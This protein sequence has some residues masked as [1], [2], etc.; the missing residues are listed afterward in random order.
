MNYYNPKI[1][2]V[3]LSLREFNVAR[4][5]L[6]DPESKITAEFSMLELFGEFGEFANNVKKCERE[7]LGLVG[8]RVTTEEL[9]DE[10]A[11]VY[12]CLDLLAMRMGI[13]PFHP[14]IQNDEIV[15]A[16]STVPTLIATLGMLFA[17]M[18]SCVTLQAARDEFDVNAGM[19]LVET[20][21]G[22]SQ[23]IIW[24][25]DLLGI[26]VNQ[27]V[28]EKFNQTSAKHGFDVLIP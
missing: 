24:I 16:Q 26:D 7:C 6:W 5:Q 4:Q 19:S 1:I 17:I 3:L 20:F 22:A 10:L 23:I 8:S 2:P 12:I 11:D 28:R 9:G 25:G 18:G 27:S 13:A 21:E 15:T 14:R